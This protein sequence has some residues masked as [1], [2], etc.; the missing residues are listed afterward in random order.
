M[1]SRIDWPD[2]KVFAFTVFDDTDLATLENIVPVYALLE[3]CGLRTT[4]S[5][6]PLSGSQEST[7]CGT[8]CEDS[9]YRN[10]LLQVRDHGF[11]I[12]YHMATHHSSVREQSIRGLNRFAEIFSDFP[13]V[14]ANHSACRENI[15]WGDSRLTGLHASIYNL[16]TRYRFKGR[17]RGHLDGDKFFW[18][19][20][21]KERVKYVRGFVFPEIN[22]LKACPIM[23]YHDPQRPYVNYWYASSEGSEVKSFSRCISE[24]NQDRLEQEGGACIMYT[25]FA[26]GFVEHGQIDS[27]FSSLIKR[28]SRKNGWFVP[29]SVLL[30]Y[31]LNTN[32]RHV[33]TD[34]ERKRLERRWLWHKLRVGTT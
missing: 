3:E 20:V 11:E 33:I 23:P 32:G 4:K 17:Y 19:D 16:L 18:G 1:G 28:L 2:G 25:H 21:C 13:K 6:W 14:M 7:W 34:R 27:R 31:L 15:Y 12:G 9:E 24:E 26:V 10:W 22:T 5:V 8:T 30:D 29:V